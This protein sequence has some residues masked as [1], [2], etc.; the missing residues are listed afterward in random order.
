MQTALKL[1][2]KYERKH[3]WAESKRE[4]TNSINF[5]SNK[6]L[7]AILMSGV[8]LQFFCPYIR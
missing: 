5:V 1:F 3:K 2:C 8:Q 6:H 4:R 7:D